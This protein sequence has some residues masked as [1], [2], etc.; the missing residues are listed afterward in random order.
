MLAGYKIIFTKVKSFFHETKSKDYE[1]LNII[2]YTGHKRA[3][4]KDTRAVQKSI[5]GT[6]RSV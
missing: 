1:R 2:E 4:Q 5:I 3:V 6:E